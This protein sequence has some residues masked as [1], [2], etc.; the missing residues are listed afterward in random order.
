MS[1]VK[2][3]LALD[4]WARFWQIVKFNGG[5]TKSIKTLFV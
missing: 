2:Q 4:K 3:V 1:I 5:I